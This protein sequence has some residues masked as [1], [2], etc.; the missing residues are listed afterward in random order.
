MTDRRGTAAR[1]A[2]LLGFGALVIAGCGGETKPGETVGG[3]PDKATSYRDDPCTRTT[4]ERRKHFHV[5][6]EGFLPP[7]V[8]VNAGGPITFVNCGKKT[9]TVTKASGPGAKF[10]K[11]LKPREI[12]ERSFPNIGTVTIIDRRNR[13]AKMVIDVSG[14]PG[15][16]QK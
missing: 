12:M 8:V 5:N 4:T 6:D 14:Q 2:V 9:H 1:A 15:Q 16:P 7:R 13:G 11:T 3:P 10:D